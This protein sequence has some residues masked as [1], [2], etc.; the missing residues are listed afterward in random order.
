MRVDWR[1]ANSVANCYRRVTRRKGLSSARA[2]LKAPERIGQRVSSCSRPSLR[3]LPRAQFRMGEVA[4]HRIAIDYRPCALLFFERV[5]QLHGARPAFYPEFD[6]GLG[7]IALD[8]HLLYVRIKSLQVQISLVCQMGLNG[9]TDG[10]LRCLARRS[11]SWTPVA[12]GKK[13]ARTNAK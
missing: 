2:R 13:K 6:V 10:I 1:G 11:R 9:P 12:T 8:R 7:V 3:S 4:A 5:T